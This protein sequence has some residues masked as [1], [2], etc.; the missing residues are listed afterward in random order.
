MDF[1]IS[2]QAR[3][4]Y[5][6]EDSLFLFTGNAIFANFH[7]ARVFAQRMNDKRD[8]RRILN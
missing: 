3:N 5:Q 2:R 1:H 7:A 4:R 8:R 6:F